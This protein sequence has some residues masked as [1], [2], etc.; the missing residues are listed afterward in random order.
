VGK[1][2]AGPSRA[3]VVDPPA[4]RLH[5]GDSETAALVR[6]VPPDSMAVEELEAAESAP[7]PAH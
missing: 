7:Q 5:L 1:A 2:W 3:A 4:L 6:I